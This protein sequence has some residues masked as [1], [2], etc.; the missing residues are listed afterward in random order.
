MNTEEPE[1]WVE[2]LLGGSGRGLLRLAPEHA[3]AYAGRR[4]FPL[5]LEK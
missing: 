2:H 1:F 3:Q 5:S 4:Y